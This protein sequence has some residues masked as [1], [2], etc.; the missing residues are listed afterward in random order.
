MISAIFVLFFSLAQAQQTT[1]TP[2]P[3]TPK[4][5][6]EFKVT[7]AG[8]LVPL[9]I[10]VYT[11]D[12]LVDEFRAQL[13]TKLDEVSKN[14]YPR[15]A[16]TTLQYFNDGST[17]CPVTHSTP[18][19]KPVIQISVTEN[20]QPGQLVQLVDYYT[21][22]QKVTARESFRSLGT[23]PKS[24]P[25]RD[26]WNGKASITL[27]SDETEKTY[28]LFDSKNKET[29][30]IRAHRVP[31][32]IQA[33]FTIFG[34]IVLSYEEYQSTEESRVSFKGYSYDLEYLDN[35]RMQHLHNHWSKAPYFKVALNKEGQLFYYLKDPGP[36]PLTRF[37]SGFSA[38]ILD[39]TFS[40]YRDGFKS[41][42]INNWPATQFV[43]SGI[44]TSRLL[45]E[46]RLNFNRL[47]SK[48][49]LQEVEDFFLQLIGNV[50]TGYIEDKRPTE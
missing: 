30:R 31:T 32:G 47:Q 49:E 12:N 44:K 48:T 46:L 26:F 10:G 13:R 25:V 2:T 39:P 9:P 19:S 4:V 34:K 41:V 18:K 37:N 5:N 23:Y 29:F 28:T 35:G 36:R 43:S 50:E 42:L 38:E 3:L 33:E 16:G 14:F 40:I 6:G 22:N 15:I 1:V 7:K 20:R 21:C 8:E 27:A 17:P 11:L 24:Q 45:D